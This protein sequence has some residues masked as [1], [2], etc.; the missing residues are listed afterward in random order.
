MPA[1][2]QAAAPK[3]D[4]A[5]SADSGKPAPAAMGLPDPKGKPDGYKAKLN[6]KVVAI[7]K[8]GKWVLP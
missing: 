8:G 6:G 2:P 1:A 4:P 3:T 5:K 7:V